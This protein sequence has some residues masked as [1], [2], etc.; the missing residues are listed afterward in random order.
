M[1]NEGSNEG[2]EECEGFAEGLKCT[3][4]LSVHIGLKWKHHQ[5]ELAECGILSFSIQ[6]L[7]PHIEL[8]EI[9]NEAV[10]GKT[11]GLPEFALE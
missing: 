6:L 10:V 2:I 4:G 9:P 5:Y 1:W 7:E 8:S 11:P 3:W